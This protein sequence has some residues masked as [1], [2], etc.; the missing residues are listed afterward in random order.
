[1]TRTPTRLVTIPFSHYCEKAR[2]SLTHCGVRFAEDPHMPLLHWLPAL[3]A[4]GG[5]TVP[6]LVADDARVLA[7]STD[8]AAW[9]DA[10]SAGA[11]RREPAAL[12]LEDDFDR[13]LGPA[14][15]RW[16]YQQ[17]LPREDLLELMRGN[18]PDW[19]LAVLRVTRPLATALLRRGLEV[20]PAGVA[21]SHA[22]IDAVFARVGELLADGRRYLTGAEFSIADLTFAALASP[23]LRPAEVPFGI[24]ADLVLAPAA[25]AQVAAWRATPAGRFALDLYAHQRGLSA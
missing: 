16:G 17:L 24:P 7:D 12:A 18:V 9:A 10:R 15:R 1:M 14:T 21:R 20:T 5:R 11:L 19:E 8:I 23:V 6:V 13:Q 4:G 22:K 25:T 3:R 2:W